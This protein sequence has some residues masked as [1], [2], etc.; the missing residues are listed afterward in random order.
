[1][2]ADVSAGLELRQD[3]AIERA[4]FADDCLRASV[5]MVPVCG[6]CGRNIDQTRLLIC[7]TASRCSLCCS[8]PVLAMRR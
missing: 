8:V 2:F 1:M 4:M 7:P 6:A 3:D 5:V